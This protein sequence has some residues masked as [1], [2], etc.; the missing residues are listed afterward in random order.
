MNPVTCTRCGW[1]VEAREELDAA[2]GELTKTVVHRA[3][4]LVGC[5]RPRDV[6]EPRDDI[7]SG[8]FF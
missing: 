5:S 8:Q 3:N 4:G 1:I 2:T 6:P 7:M